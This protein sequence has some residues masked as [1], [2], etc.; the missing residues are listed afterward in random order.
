MIHSP[1]GSWR[2]PPSNRVT[3]R[4]WRAG[5]SGAAAIG[6]AA[7][8]MTE[9]DLLLLLVQRELIKKGMIH[10]VSAALDQFTLAEK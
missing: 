4:V 9:D 2:L 7:T 10:S 5:C 8:A 1:C 3:A 6:L